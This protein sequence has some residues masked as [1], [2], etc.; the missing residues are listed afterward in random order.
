MIYRVLALVL[1]LSVLSSATILPS[2][3]QYMINRHKFKSNE[4]SI[5][6]KEAGKNSVVASYNI[7]REM[8]PASVIKVYSTYASLLELGYGYSWQTKFYYSG[9][10]KRGVLSGDIAIKASGDPTLNSSDIPR[11]V[12]AFKSKGIR[13]IKG[14]IIIDRS[15]FKPT[16]RDSSHFDKN[17]YSAYN[18]M[19]DAMMFN[20]HMSKFTIYSKGG[21]H[22]VDKA[23]PGN[24]YRVQ[25]SIKSVS[26]SCRGK[27]SWPSIRVDHSTSIPTLVVSGRLSKSCGKRT[28]RY[29]ITKPYREFYYSLVNEFKR[30]G[31]K[32]NGKMRLARVPTG[33][34]KFYTNY[35]DSLEKIISITAKKS[36]NLFARHLLLT[37]GA[38]IYGTPSSLEKGRRAVRHILNRYHLL[39][40]NRCH[41]D[42]GCGLSRSSRITARS[43]SKVLDHAYKRYGKRW[44]RTL[45]IAGV[46]GTIKR[47]FRGSIVQNRAWMKTGTLNNAKNIVGYVQSRSGK[48]Y[49]VVIL[50]NGKRARWHGAALENEIIKWLIAYNG[51]GSRVSID[52]ITQKI[53][54]NSRKL[55]GGNDITAAKVAPLRESPKRYFIQVGSYASKPKR[56]FLQKI[57]DSGFSYKVIKKE[58]NYKVLVGPYHRQKDATSAL[59]RINKSMP[60]AYMVQM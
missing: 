43:M 48:L 59:S 53:D 7:D 26:G 46:D 60:S 9:R 12:S 37:L 32:Y 58:G 30:Q 28:H 10:V 24:S 57:I 44:M 33:A 29:I 20:Q 19:P 51:S 34:K 41:I 2:D 13:V 40:S 36:N 45:S 22:Y 16:K 17:V 56:E 54:E 55:W 18:A 1:F 15:Y 50:T 5:Y 49:T 31:I 35:S 39:D 21:K 4:V 23:I 6:I 38:K 47:R 14:D 42:N 52:P 25:N 11:I 3:I 27:N 8:M